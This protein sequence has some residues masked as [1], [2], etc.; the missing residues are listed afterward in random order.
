M[1]LEEGRIRWG[2]TDPTVATSRASKAE[3]FENLNR[4]IAMV[5]LSDFSHD[6]GRRRG[7]LSLTEKK[8]NIHIPETQ[9]MHNHGIQQNSRESY[10]SRDRGNGARYNGYTVE[11]NL[12]NYQT[13]Q[14]N[15]TN[16]AHAHRTIFTQHP[17]LPFGARGS[18][19]LYQ[20]NHPQR[21]T[22][23]YANICRSV[24]TGCP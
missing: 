8:L 12:G 2:C 24:E 19:G 23:G 9:G 11:P 21:V 15:D 18:D 14:C 16:P 22:R 20:Y 1:F 13:A 3:T 10:V 4:K 5:G 6:S 7:L 17:Q